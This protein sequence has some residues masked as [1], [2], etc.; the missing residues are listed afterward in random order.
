MIDEII[1][2]RISTRRFD[3]RDVSKAT[4][5]DVIETAKYAPSG[6]NRQP[7]RIKILSD[8]MKESLL[9]ILRSKMNVL[10]EHGSLSVSIK[11]IEQCG[12]VLLVFNPF[13]YKEIPYSRNRLLMDTQSI[14][15]FIQNVLLCLAE[16]DLS[17]LWINDIYYAKDEIER[18]FGQGYE[19]IAAL[20]VGYSNSSRRTTERLSL[21]EIMTSQTDF[22]VCRLP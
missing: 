9:N 5:L 4:V 6:K 21:D 14:G 15:A 18:R 20:A 7:W 13:S 8:E 1:K 12:I 10:K 16:K 19:V 17:S 3:D 22:L 2:K 11:A